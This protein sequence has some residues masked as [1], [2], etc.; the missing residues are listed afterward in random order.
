[1]GSHDPF[2]W[3]KH[4]LWAKEGPWVK[5]AIWLLT[6]KRQKSPWHPY[7]HVVCNIPLESS[8]QW[9]QLCFKTHLLFGFVATPLWPSVGVK[10]NTPKVG[11]LGSS[12]TSECLGFNGKA[13]NTSHEVFLVSL[14]RPWSI[15]IENGLALAIWTFVTQVM[16]KRRA[17]SQT[18]NLTPDH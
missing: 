4:K 8:R 9:L 15:D 3:L 13:Q 11:D 2:E 17:G 6:P 16:G 18:G 1:M 14:E 5:W 10:P 7:V 12:G